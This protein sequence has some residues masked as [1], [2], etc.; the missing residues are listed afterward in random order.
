MASTGTDRPVPVNKKEPQSQTQALLAPH[1]SYQPTQIQ[2]QQY[3]RGDSATGPMT[4][5]P[6]GT[7]PP[8]QYKTHIPSRRQE[9]QAASEWCFVVLSH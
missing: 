5:H 4:T 9:S 1:R 2:L 3:Y 6:L 7:R 8:A